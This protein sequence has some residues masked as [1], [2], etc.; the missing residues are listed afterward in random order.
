MRK[1]DLLCRKLARRHNRFFVVTKFDGRRYVVHE[2]DPN[3]Q[4]SW[5]LA[6][7]RRVADVERFL[8]DKFN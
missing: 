6:S 8:L 3:S 1:L 4:D 5:L 7:F 2:Y